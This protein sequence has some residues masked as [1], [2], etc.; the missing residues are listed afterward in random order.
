[1]KNDFGK[2]EEFYR[3]ETERLSIAERLLKYLVLI[4]TLAIF[5]RP[6]RRDSIV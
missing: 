5:H 2:N 4:D 3:E 1:M 6:H